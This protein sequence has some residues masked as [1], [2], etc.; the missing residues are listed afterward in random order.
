MIPYGRQSI[1][2]L[3]IDAVARVLRSDWLTT[4]PMVNQ[5]EKNLTNF[6][7]AECITVSSGTAALHA[8]YVAIGLK[9]GDEVITPPLT[10]VATQ[11]TAVMCGA[12]VKFADILP[13]TGCIDPISVA[14][15]ITSK[16]KAIVTVDFAGHPSELEELKRI[17][18]EN[19]IYLIEDAAHSLGS[20]YREKNVGTIADITTF[21]F[22]PTKNIATGEGGAI[23]S[24]HENLLKNAR[25]FSRQGLIRD[26]SAFQITTEGPWHQEVHRIGLNYRLPDI[27]CALGISQLERINEF[28]TKRREIFE[29]YCEL[30]YGIDEIIL[31]TVKDYVDPMWHLFPI[32]VPRE[33][34]R[35][36]FDFLRAN[37]VLV[38]VNYLPAF[39]H[40]VF[41]FPK[42]RYS[43][44]PN[45]L[46]YY[47]RE[48]SL[49]IFSDLTFDQVKNISNL[50]IS[51]LRT[52]E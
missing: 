2:D 52:V 30:L 7:G 37:G 13:E 25:E 10:F 17:A 15:L 16:T 39:M 21:S 9:D 40:P 14:S 49:P 24:P 38:Q 28:K 51:G 26:E 43:D 35:K 48:I 33:K 36:L 29:A 23:A 18:T 27:L 12:V 46:D 32:R 44:F 20:I 31:P 41:R 19:G 4:G 6:V 5:F 8:A 1:N 50:V 42:D 45:S 47:A 11:A 3:D 22:F 34:R